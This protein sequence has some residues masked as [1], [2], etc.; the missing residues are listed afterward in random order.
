MK[1]THKVPLFASGVKYAHPMGNTPVAQ[2]ILET[3]ALEESSEVATV[4]HNMQF[5]TQ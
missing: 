3:T 4:T 1:P 2:C 5:T